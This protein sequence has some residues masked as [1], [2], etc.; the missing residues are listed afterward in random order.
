MVCTKDWEPRH[1]LDFIRIPKEQIGTPWSRP[2]PT[3]VFV[4]V[5]SPLSTESDEYIY[6]ET[7]DL[8]NTN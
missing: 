6:S 5:S 1:P 4:Q 3:Y 2:V 8:L 7:D